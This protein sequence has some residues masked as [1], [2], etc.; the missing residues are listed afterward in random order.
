M[1]TCPSAARPSRRNLDSADECSRSGPSS[2]SG[3]RK[4][5]T[6]SSNATPCFTAL[7]SAFRG[8][9]SNTYSVYTECQGMLRATGHRRP[10]RRCARPTRSG[11]PRV[12][13]VWPGPRGEVLLMVVQAGWLAKLLS[14]H[15]IAHHRRQDPARWRARLEAHGFALE[16]EGADNRQGRL[17]RVRRPPR[18]SQTNRS[19]TGDGT[20]RRR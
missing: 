16:E 11:A 12:S 7:V 13:R 5:V 20:A 4:T 6:A 3:S 8:S 14:P 18:L 2:A 15:A 1:S 9:H 10:A 19:G 17:I